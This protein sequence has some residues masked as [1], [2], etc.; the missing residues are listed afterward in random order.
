[1]KLEVDLSP[2]IEQQLTEIASR[3][4]QNAMENE[5]K[6]QNFP[7]WMDLET[8]CEYL[9]VSRTNLSK[10]I[11]ELDFPVSVIN[12]TKR[13]NRKKVDEWMAQFEI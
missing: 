10:F 13:C 7:E 3:V 5:L 12:Q 11:K 4:W 1:M 2:T 9:Q 8:T 6:K